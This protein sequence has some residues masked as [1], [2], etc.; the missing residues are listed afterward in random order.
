MYLIYNYYLIVA[1]ACLGVVL[2]VNVN[3]SCLIPSASQM[4]T[5]S[6]TYKII[7]MDRVDLEKI[8]SGN[9]AKRAKYC[10]MDISCFVNNSGYG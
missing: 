3:S 6:G 10:F 7:Y 8:K 5:S 1:L 9:I 4:M 2:S